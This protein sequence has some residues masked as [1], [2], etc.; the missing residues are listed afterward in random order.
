MIAFLLL[1]SLLPLQ[2]Q[3]TPLSLPDAD[4]LAR[5]GDYAA[6][7]VRYEA[8]ATTRPEP[9][10][11]LR[12]AFAREQEGRI[13]DALWALRRAYERRPER[14]ILRRMD[15]LAATHH[16][17]GYEYGDRRFFLT[18][19]RR[20][21]QTLLETALFL[22]VGLTTALVLR[23]RRFPLRRPWGGILVTY[24]ALAALAANILA[25]DKLN[26]EV[27]VC[28]PAALM[29]GPAAGAR[30]LTTL[31]AGQQLSVTG[32]PRDI[33]LPVRWQ[34]QQTWIRRTDLYR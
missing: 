33:W 14:L 19:L 11:L 3:L 23:A 1:L 34:G 9:A 10:V 31:P 2:A 20:Y 13:P 30:W 16:L 17:V 7:A 4:S 29:S 24:A 18:L 32:R 5:V 6:A 26:Q 15:A 22:G 27:I 21:Y 8:L 12:L 28:R 25:P